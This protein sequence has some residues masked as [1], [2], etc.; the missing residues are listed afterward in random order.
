MSP[1]A[2]GRRITLVSFLLLILSCGGSRPASALAPFCPTL[3]PP[4][5]NETFFGPAGEA[6]API[7]VLNRSKYYQADRVAQVVVSFPNID[8][9]SRQILLL[10]VNTSNAVTYKTYLTA[11]SPSLSRADVR[12]D[13]T[14]LT[15]A[16]WTVTAIVVDSTQFPVPGIAQ[17]S[18]QLNLAAGEPASSRFPAEGVAVRLLPQTSASNASWGISTGIPMP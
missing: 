15:P 17:P 3:G 1:V 13:L 18:A 4:I 7:V 12:V 6:A 8:M 11:P 16:T 5:C 10:V 14:R 2:A 9:M